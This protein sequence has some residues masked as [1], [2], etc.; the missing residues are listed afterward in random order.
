MEMYQVFPNLE[1]FAW[2]DSYADRINR[3]AWENLVKK[4]GK[5]TSKARQL[6]DSL[7]ETDN[8]ILEEV[9][10]ETFRKLAEKISLVRVVTPDLVSNQIR[11]VAD[12]LQEM[13]LRLDKLL[14]VLDL[15]YHEQANQEFRKL[16]REYHWLTDLREL[17]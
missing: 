10:E 16:M 6:H 2:D 11:E 14:A 7:W 5:L 15:G 13:E 17:I 3:E 12:R 8:Q 1:T 9:Y 4:V